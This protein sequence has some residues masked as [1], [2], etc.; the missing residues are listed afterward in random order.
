MPINKYFNSGFPNS[1]QTIYLIEDLYTECIGMLGVEAYYIPRNLNPDTTDYIYGEDALKT[2]TSS[3][4]VEVYVENFGAFENQSEIFSKFGLQ[5]K[6]DM[7]VLLSRRTF[8]SQV[9]V[10]TTYNRPIEGDLLWMPYIKGTGILYEIKFVDPDPDYNLLGRKFPYYY[11]LKLE[12]FKYSN[13]IIQTGFPDIDRIAGVEGYG[14]VFT[15]ST[16]SGTYTLNEVVYQGTN[17]AN[18][19][20]TAIVADWNPSGNTLTVTNI[21]G[22][23]TT[24]INIIGSVSNAQYNLVTYNALA[25]NPQDNPFDNNLIQTEG[26]DYLNT[27]ETN[28]FGIV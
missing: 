8:M 6:D 4:Q 2:F 16:G 24:N 20:N 15:I 28:P 14:I 19:N 26:L 7:T 18:A 17:L 22:S 23:F 27:T 13:E 10:N 12:D 11:K 9:E 25:G 21:K 1:S 3:F 5:I